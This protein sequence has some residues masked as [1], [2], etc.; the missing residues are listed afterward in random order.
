MKQTVF[1]DIDGTIVFHEGDLEQMMK[2]MHLLPKTVSKLKEWRRNGVYIVLT[3]AR[4]EGIRSHVE[5]QL[6]RRG[7]FYDQLI[8][9]LPTGPRTVINDT[10][11]DGTITAKAHP[12]H[13]DQGIG[14][15][16]L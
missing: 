12:L 9:G 1:L 16:E 10:K 11:P 3:T 7:V 4:P 13:R 2:Q 8:M 5:S 6:H 15:I 14:E